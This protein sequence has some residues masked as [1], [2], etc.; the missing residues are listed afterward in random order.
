MSKSEKIFK[1][2]KSLII[3]LICLTAYFYLQKTLY[4]SQKCKLFIIISALVF[5]TLFIIKIIMIHKNSNRNTKPIK[6]KQNDDD[7]RG[8]RP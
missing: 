7:F 3:E 1:E 4:L 8:Y 2:I 6:F 5:I